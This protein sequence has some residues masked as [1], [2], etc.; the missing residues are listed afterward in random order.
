MRAP[1]LVICQEGGYEGPSSITDPTSLTLE[2][3]ALEQDAK[4][5]PEEKRRRRPRIVRAVFIA[6][7]LFL[8]AP[9][10]LI[11]LYRLDFVRPVSTLM[12]A[13]L[14]TLQGYDRRWVDFE[15]ISPNVVRAVMMSEDG[16][17]CNHG[18]VDWAQLQSVIDDAMAG[19]ATRGAST[20]PMQTAK[21]LFLWNGR[22]F[23]RK[24]LELPLAL[25]LDAVWPK[26]RTME[27]YLNIAE[28]GPGIYG[29]EAAAQH[30]FKTS[31]AKLSRQQAALLAVSL[32]N[33]IDRVASKPGPGLKRLAGVVERRARASGDYITCLYG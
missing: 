19:E 22:S 23:I 20:I 18:G 28:W 12:L 14:A 9:Y 30:H 25:A 2:V 6:L 15:D 26:Q 10:L 11:L 8:A 13:D 31:A 33:P 21:N 32:P 7:F 29:I 3:E 27:I 1:R 16:Q 24:G 17:Y 5:V 4:F